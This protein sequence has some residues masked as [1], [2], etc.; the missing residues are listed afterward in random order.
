MHIQL[1]EEYKQQQLDEI[2]I[3]GIAKKGAK[4]VGGA[5]GKGL[6]KDMVPQ[7]GIEKQSMVLK[8]LVDK[9]DLK[10]LKKN[11]PKHT[12]RQ[13]HLQILQAL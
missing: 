13:V 11:L 8:T 3:A 2:D 10:L 7:A 12:K 4:A 9:L 6:D 5:L 1:F